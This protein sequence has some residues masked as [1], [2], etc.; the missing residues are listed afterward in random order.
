MHW[1]S[2]S[3]IIAIGSICLTAALVSGESALAQAMQVVG[4][5]STNLNS[6]AS[7]SNTA[8]FNP[9]DPHWAMATPFGFNTAAPG[10]EAYALKLNSG[11]LALYSATNTE[12]YGAHRIGSTGNL[13]DPLPF[14]S[15]TQPGAWFSGLGDSAWRSSVVASYKSNPND[16]LGGLYTTANFGMTSFKTDPAGLPGLTNFTS[17]NDASAMTVS[18]GVGYQI[19]PHLT[20]EGS[21]GFTQMQQGS[22]FH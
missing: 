11:T 8:G 2:R 4:P 3:R 1:G 6:S 22:N 21:V 16:T 14:S 19:S 7:S 5:S 9:Y 20:I 10:V 18:A 12:D 13:F 15:S 17:G